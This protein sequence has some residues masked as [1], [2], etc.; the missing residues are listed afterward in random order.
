MKNPFRLGTLVIIILIGLWVITGPPEEEPPEK[1]K[2]PHFVDAYIKNFTMTSMNEEG[3]PDYTLTAQ[4]MEHYND[5]GE[6]MI[7]APVFNIKRPDSN[8]RVSARYGNIDND[9]IWV[10]LDEDVVMQ[11]QNTENPIQ[12]K[13]SRMR[14][15][16]KTRIAN[17]DEPVDINQ[18]AMVIKSNGMIFNSL[19]GQLQLLAGVNGTYVKP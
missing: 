19:T 2:D 17:S 15:N 12:I 7:T 3:A 13:T 16:I 10:T 1:E 4:L 6:S 18:G 14:Y 8:W 9:N 11:Q 5:T